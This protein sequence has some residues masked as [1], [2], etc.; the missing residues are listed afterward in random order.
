[1]LRGIGNLFKPK[2]F[3]GG[4]DKAEKDLVKAIALFATDKPA[5]PAPDWGHA[6]AYAW[7]GQVYA[8]RKQV[9][10]AREAYRKALELRPDFGWVAHELLPALDRIKR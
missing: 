9:D 6:E 10:E 7:L 5:P 1:M 4:A 8:E 3:G 2:L